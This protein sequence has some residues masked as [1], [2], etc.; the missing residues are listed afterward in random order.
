MTDPQQIPPASPYGPPHVQ[1]PVPRPVSAPPQ[2]P[3]AP[4][5]Q[6]DLHR[7]PAPYGSGVPRPRTNPLSIVSLCASGSI[8]VLF[9][10]VLFLPAIALLPGLV[11]V[12]TGHIALS[13]I[14]RSGERGHG[15]ALA[16]LIIGY[17]IIAVGAL[18]LIGAIATVVVLGT[19]GLSL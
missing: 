15:F 10:A 17:A 3:H 18:G 19:R 2:H 9:I 1:G 16:G 7:F 6:H 14:A 13:Q 5:P 11:G 4:Q 12:A 8:I